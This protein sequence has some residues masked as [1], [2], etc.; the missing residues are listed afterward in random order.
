MRGTDAAG[1][2][3]GGPFGAFGIT[4][5]SYPKNHKKK[6]CKNKTK[7]TPKKISKS[8]QNRRTPKKLTQFCVSFFDDIAKKRQPKKRVSFHL[9]I[10][11]N[12]II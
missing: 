4:G 3:P 10:T 1:A 5:G 9:L 2:P 6:Y 11:K 7:K 8:K 12:K